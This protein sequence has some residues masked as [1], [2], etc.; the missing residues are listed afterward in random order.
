MELKKQ[1][2]SVPLRPNVVDPFTR[3]NTGTNTGKRNSSGGC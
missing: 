2:K 1:Q 3:E